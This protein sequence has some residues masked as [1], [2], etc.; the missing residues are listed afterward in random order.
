MSLLQIDEVGVRSVLTPQDGERAVS[1]YDFSLNPYQG[2]GM[3]CS[4]CYV[5]R[6][7]FAEMA[8]TQ[9]AAPMRSTQPN[10]PMGSG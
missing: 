2:C 4:Y 10:A 6:Y 7:P 3:G 8:S 1:L 9:P 5:S